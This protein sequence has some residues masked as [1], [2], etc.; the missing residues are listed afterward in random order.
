MRSKLELEITEIVE[1]FKLQRPVA[2]DHFTMTCDCG[3]C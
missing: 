3:C 2:R 1:T